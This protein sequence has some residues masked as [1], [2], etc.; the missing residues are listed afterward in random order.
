VSGRPSTFAAA[1]RN[2]RLLWLGQLVSMSGT[3][4]QAAAI[5]WHISLLAPPGWK[6]LSLG[7]VGLARLGPILVFGLW[8]GVMADA[9]DR[10]RLMLI[11]Q[12]VMM[13]VAVTLAL[14]TAATGESLG[15][16]ARRG[17]RRG[18]GPPT[19][20]PA[21]ARELVPREHC[22]TPSGSTRSFPDRSV[23][24]P[25]SGITLATSVLPCTR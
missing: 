15:D 16:P 24:G 23:V 6:A 4:M 2:F 12:V 14:V 17:L 3:M 1:H 19:P 25:S 5:L 8:S 10:R 7:L 13:L 20:P 21:V 22:P 9:V 11:A 18:G